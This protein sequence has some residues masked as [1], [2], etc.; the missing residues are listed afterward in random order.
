MSGDLPLSRAE[1]AEVPAASGR[2]QLS[3]SIP[4]G[5]QRAACA[6]QADLLFV[7]D[8]TGSMSD[9]ITALIATLSGFCDE[10]A[11]MSLDLEIAVLAFGDLSLNEATVESP[12]LRDTEAVKR[13]LMR[14]PRYNG[15][16]NGGESS[17]AA[18]QAALRKPGRATATRVVVLLTDEPDIERGERAAAILGMLRESECIV[19]CISPK[20]RYFLELARASGGA[21]QQISARSSLGAVKKLLAA[22]GRK[23]AEQ[24]RRVHDRQLGAGSVRRLRARGGSGHTP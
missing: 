16:G 5:A 7:L 9:K 6:A 20:E 13:L 19:Y 18:L 24:L 8:T 23:V 12:F 1:A 10:I 17:L 11:A 3:G 22:L 4:A 15:G 14:V 2:S 21:W